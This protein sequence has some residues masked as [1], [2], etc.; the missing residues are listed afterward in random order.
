MHEVH[1]ELGPDNT[2]KENHSDERQQQSG[3]QAQL[4][5]KNPKATSQ[6]RVVKIPWHPGRFHRVS[7]HGGEWSSLVSLARSLEGVREAARSDEILR[8]IRR[9]DL[10]RF[11]ALTE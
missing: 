9:S 4:G 11:R 1:A 2:D 6:D 3:T 5:R 8:E 10:E 7:C